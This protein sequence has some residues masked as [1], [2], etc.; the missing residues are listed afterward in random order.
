ML[1]T[2]MQEDTQRLCASKGLTN[3][4]NLW[5]SRNQDVLQASAAG[6]LQTKSDGGREGGREGGSSKQLTPFHIHTIHYSVLCRV[7]PHLPAGVCIWGCAGWGTACSWTEAGPCTGDWTEGRHIVSDSHIY[8]TITT[9]VKW[10][11]IETIRSDI[12]ILYV[13]YLYSLHEVG[14]GLARLEPL[15][16][17]Q[18]GVIKP[19]CVHRVQLDRQAGR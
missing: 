13:L 18:L 9:T 11:C 10:L 15:A 8:I 5:C 3:Q 6:S 19:R 12:I 17:S 4:A 7:R 14:K 1:L 2:C 16:V